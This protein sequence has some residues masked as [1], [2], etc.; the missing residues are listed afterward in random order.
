M[1]HQEDNHPASSQ[2]K[3]DDGDCHGQHPAAEGVYI[4]M[5]SAAILNAVLVDH[6][7]TAHLLLD[8]LQLERLVSGLHFQVAAAVLD[9]R[10]P[11][12]KFA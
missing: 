4:G 11:F 6:T 9:A 5:K 7:E 10:N 1:D 8:P 2:E 3:R 12:R